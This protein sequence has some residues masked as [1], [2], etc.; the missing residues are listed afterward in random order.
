MPSQGGLESIDGKSGLG[1]LEKA[2]RKQERDGGIQALHYFQAW[3][4]G[5]TS[6]SQSHNS[7]K[8]TQNRGTQEGIHSEE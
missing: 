5:G 6:I 7:K 2:S 1:W 4:Q 3:R 8:P